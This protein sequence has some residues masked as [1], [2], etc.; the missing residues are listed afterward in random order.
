MRIIPYGRQD[1]NQDDIDAVVAVLRSDFL[2]Q[3]STVP[4]FEKAVTDY[5]FAQQAIA[6]TNATSA[7]HI[8]CLALGI[9]NGDIVWTTPI[10]FG[11]SAGFS[12]Q[13]PHYW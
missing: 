13:K 11:A 10:T 2:T 4:D 1:I 9:G 8:A 5:C 6:V 12:S 7:L 3:G